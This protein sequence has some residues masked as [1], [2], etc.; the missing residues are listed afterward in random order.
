M[1][2]FRDL[3]AEEVECRVSMIKENGLQL[4]LYKTARTD[5][6]ILDETVGSEN[7]QSDYK[8]IDG[9]LFCGIGIRVGEDWIW[10]W[11]TGV[12]SNMEAQKGEASDARKRAGYAW[13]IGRELYTAPFIWV[14]ATGD[15]YKANKDSKGV[16]KTTERFDVS[17][18]TIKDGHIAALTIVNS[19]GK[20][21][22]AKE[23]KSRKA[24]NTRSAAK[25][26]EQKAEPAKAEEPKGQPQRET[27]PCSICGKDVDIVFAQKSIRK[28]GEIYCSKECFEMRRIEA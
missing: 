13:G 27:R 26:K 6:Q 20:I 25:Q 7:W 1:I 15:N 28:Y 21:V 4:L 16:W 5:M 17:E 24:Q 19:G 10:K 9:K 2:T 3:T 8:S 11:D 22:Y 12:P 18:I 14:P 23:Q